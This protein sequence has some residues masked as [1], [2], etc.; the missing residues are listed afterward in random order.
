MYASGF[1]FSVII[2]SLVT[3]AATANNL[4]IPLLYSGLAIAETVGSFIGATLLTAAFTSTIDAGGE[5]AGVPFFVCS[6]SSL[7][8]IPM[9]C[10]R[11]YIAEVALLNISI[12][13]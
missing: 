5:I 3:S 13:G 4:S 7:P 8:R 2:R 1:G 12:N 10:Y 11:R 6:V 9:L